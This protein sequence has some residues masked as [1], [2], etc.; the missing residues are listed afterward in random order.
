MEIPG[1]GDLCVTRESGMPGSG[2]GLQ[3]ALDGYAKFLRHRDLAPARQRLC[4]A[5][6]RTSSGSC[7]WSWDRAGT[8]WGWRARP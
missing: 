3:G 5:R 4:L 6:R 2:E 7:C 1:Y 8:G